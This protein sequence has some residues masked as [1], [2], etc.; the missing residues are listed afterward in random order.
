MRQRRHRAFRRGWLALYILAVGG[1]GALASGWN[2]APRSTELSAAQMVSLRFPDES[3]ELPAP[4]GR[5]PAEMVDADRLSLLSPGPMAPQTAV[6][7]EATPS[8]PPQQAT[9]PVQPEARPLPLPEQAA[10]P[11]PPVAHHIASRPKLAAVHKPANRPGFVLNDAQIA[12]IKSRL[13]LSPDQ[14]RMWPA[15]E[16]ALR[17]IAYAKAHGEARRR[18]APK[19]ASELANIDPNSPEVQGLKSAAFPLILSF[20]SEQKSEVRTLAHVM[21]LDQ[22]ASQF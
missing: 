8:L 5:A 21:G 1:I 3:E 12:S 13:Q 18:G 20:N 15:V 19:S 10:V 6:Q 17:S 11:L 2:G 4:D 7:P 16:A 14:E 22:L 9:T